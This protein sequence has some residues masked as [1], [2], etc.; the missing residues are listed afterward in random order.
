M[1]AKKLKPG[2]QVRVIAPAMSLAVPSINKFK[3]AS[4][5]NF[6]KI[7]LNVSFS[8]NVYEI[9]EFKSSSMASRLSDLHEAFADKSIKMVIPVCGGFNSNQLLKYIDYD[10]IKK[11]PKILCGYSD[12]TAL[13]TAI[14]TKTGLVTYSCPDF[15]HFGEEIEFKYTLDYFKKC[16]FSN[17]AFEIKPAVKW[18]EDPGNLPENNKDVAIKNK[19][20]WLINEGQTNG[21][22]LGGDQCTLKLLQGTEFMPNIKNSILFL[23]DDYET[24]I[25]TIDRDLQSIIHLPG[26]SKVRGIVFGRFQIKTKMTKDA[27]TKI[28][29][30]K[31]EL[32][33]I[34]VIANV[35]FGHTYPII[36]FPIGGQAKLI[37][38]NNKIKLEITKH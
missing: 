3:E 23:E 15:L 26:F 1:I 29:K 11:N 10:L 13:N 24:H 17:K 32:N 5:K 27:L 38:K 12:I 7:G 14:F 19:G 6:K 31:K 28:V 20:Y 37:A 30:T 2:D 34:P 33:K 36:S 16:F 22:I 4:I 21:E 25:A 35:D 9:D 18:R 8:N